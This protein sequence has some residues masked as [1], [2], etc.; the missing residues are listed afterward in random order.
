MI[1]DSDSLEF[2][3]LLHANEIASHFD[4]VGHGFVARYTGRKAVESTSLLRMVGAPQGMIMNQEESSYFESVIK[5]FF[6]H[7]LSFRHQT[8][9]GQQRQ[10]HQY[11]WLS[12]QE[13]EM[14]RMIGCNDEKMN[15][16]QV[17]VVNVVHNELVH[18]SQDSSL[19][20][21]EKRLGIVHIGDFFEDSGVILL[22][23]L[24]NGG[25][26]A[27][28]ITDD[29]SF[30]P[31]FTD[32]VSLVLATVNSVSS[33]VNSVSSVPSMMPV[34]SSTL[35]PVVVNNTRSKN[36]FYDV[37]SIGM[38]IALTLFVIAMLLF[39]YLLFVWY[40]IRKEEENDDGGIS[41]CTGT[42]AAVRFAP[43]IP[44][45]T[46][47]EALNEVERNLGW[48][49]DEGTLS[50]IS[51]SIVTYHKEK[52]SCI[53]KMI[54]GN[55]FFQRR[56]EKSSSDDSIDE[57]L[58]WTT[59]TELRNSASQEQTAYSSKTYLFS[60]NQIND[61][62][63]FD[64]NCNAPAVRGLIKS[65]AT[66]PSDMP[67]VHAPDSGEQVDQRQVD[68]IDVI[69]RAYERLF[70][71]MENSHVR[72]PVMQRILESDENLSAA[73]SLAKPKLRSISKK[74]P[75]DLLSNS[76]GACCT[77]SATPLRESSFSSVSRRA[78]EGLSERAFCPPPSRSQ[79]PS[80]IGNK[81]NDVSAVD[82]SEFRCATNAPFLRGQE[83]IPLLPRNI[84]RR[85]AFST[86]TRTWNGAIPTDKVLSEDNCIDSL[87]FPAILHRSRSVLESDAN[88]AKR[89]KSQ[90]ISSRRASE[91]G[92]FNFTSPILDSSQVR[93]ISFI[94]SAGIV[95]SSS[96]SDQQKPDADG[97]EG[98]NGCEGRRQGVKQKKRHS[99]P[100]TTQVSSLSLS[101]DGAEKTNCFHVNTTK[102]EAE[103]TAFSEP[104]GVRTEDIILS[105]HNSQ[106][107]SDDSSWSSAF[108]SDESS[109]DSPKPVWIQIDEEQLSFFG[110]K[111]MIEEIRRT[112]TTA[113]V[114]PIGSVCFSESD[115]E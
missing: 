82:S 39:F 42:E 92:S 55:L 58:D 98:T 8:V 36:A 15:M 68:L 80:G 76:M 88:P 5:Q 6:N 47:S 45:I 40:R 72:Q 94:R 13:G 107:S 111:N 56:T 2:Y 37:E 71:P 74:T 20:I 87:Q 27:N 100:N 24:S 91:R 113:D 65:S 90:S 34:V 106:V 105:E 62:E 93:S 11:R 53:L 69:D 18:N 108:C 22:D 43:H 50:T 14:R 99:W 110:V 60:G 3:T 73:S 79:I 97:R 70:Q 25:G 112:V 32:V 61:G 78:D 19:N 101:L 85:R 54:L 84:G 104:E 115:S 1:L 102:P 109:A 7:I 9:Q 29:I 12:W 38:E 52:K 66:L 51:R 64:P 41:M 31:Y 114:S 16:M 21:D 89:V 48:D 10:Q 63:S 46:D 59:N 28:E 96:R 75:D 44:P 4:I 17:L 33:A 49:D 23:L 83:V 35:Q 67:A 77:I 103:V 30:E 86:L 57:K 81:V 95:Y 26:Y